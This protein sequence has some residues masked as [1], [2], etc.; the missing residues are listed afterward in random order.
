MIVLIQKG[1]K[2][3]SCVQADVSRPS[4]SYSQIT[5]PQEEA[6]LKESIVQE[7]IQI[8]NNLSIYL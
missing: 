2:I 3:L 4:P 6:P 1:N 7:E 5:Y 8:L